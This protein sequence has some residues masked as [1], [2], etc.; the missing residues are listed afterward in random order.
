MLEMVQNCLEREPLSILVH[1][2]ANRGVK[3]YSDTMKQNMIKEIFF[4]VS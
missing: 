2:R 4:C 1:A 3:G